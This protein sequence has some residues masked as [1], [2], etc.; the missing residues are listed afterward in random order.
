MKVKRQT[1]LQFRRQPK[2]S[3]TSASTRPITTLS[4]Y[5][6]LISLCK[7]LSSA[8]IVHLAATPT[9][10]WQY[11]ASSPRLLKALIQGSSC[12]GT[13]IVAQA[14]VFGYWNASPERATRKCRGRAAQPCRDCGAMVCNVIL[15]L[16]LHFCLTA[17]NNVQMCRFHVEYPK[18]GPYAHDVTGSPEEYLDDEEQEMWDEQWESDE[19][20]LSDCIEEGDINREDFRCC[21]ETLKAE[22]MFASMSCMSQCLDCQ[23]LIFKTHYFDKGPMCDCDGVYGHF[24]K[25]WR[26]IPCVLVEEAT[27][28]TRQQKYERICKYI[29]HGV[30][31]YIGVSNARPSPRAL[32]IDK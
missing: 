11:V 29:G 14:R 12:D 32:C 19:K 8:D 27:L 26:C 9:E 7:N 28:V 24:C 5:E 4:Q 15:A 2:M 16:L 17:T 25:E 6:L 18:Y 10:R 23:P 1:K 30:Y 21:V 22:T 13:G 31:Q 3:T 20:Y